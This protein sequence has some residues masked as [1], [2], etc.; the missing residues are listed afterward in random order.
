MRDMS[1][2]DK[3]NAEAIAYTIADPSLW[4]TT[5]YERGESIAQ[6]MNYM[7]VPLMKGDNNRIA[8]WNVIHSYLYFD[9]KTEPK[10]KNL[11]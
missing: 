4:S 1:L 9:E 6:R 2:D 3:G 5:Q 11:L 7:G 10:L 8:G